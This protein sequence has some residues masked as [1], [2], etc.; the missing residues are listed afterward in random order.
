MEEMQLC[1]GGSA[2]AARK[3]V[4]DPGLRPEIAASATQNID[5]QGDVAWRTNKETTK[6][7]TQRQQVSHSNL[8]HSNVRSHLGCTEPV[9]RRRF[10]LH[11]DPQRAEY[12]GRRANLKHGPRRRVVQLSS[13]GIEAGRVGRPHDQCLPRKPTCLQEYHGEPCNAVDVMIAH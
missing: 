13:G 4:G 2:N 9:R 10:L 6:M 3:V 8:S 7:Q 5:L 12:C 1:T 11:C